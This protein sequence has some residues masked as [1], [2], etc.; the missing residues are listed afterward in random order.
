M[1]T[2]KKISKLNINN[3]EYIIKDNELNS[4]VNNISGVV[5]NINTRVSGLQL[6]MPDNSK[7]LHIGNGNI[8]TEQNI[9]I[10]EFDIYNPNIYGGYIYNDDGN[11][12]NVW[13]TLFINNDEGAGEILLDDDDNTGF[14]QIVRNTSNGTETLQAAL[15][16][17]NNVKPD[18]NA[19]SGSDAEILNKPNYASSITAGGAANMSVGIPYGTIQSGSTSTNKIATVNDITE[20]KTGIICIIQ[21]DATSSASG[22]TLNV[23]NLGAKKVYRTTAPTA[24]STTEFG[25][26]YAMGFMYDETLNS[27]AGGWRLLELYNSNTTYTNASLGQGYGTCSTAEATLA[28]TSSISN[29]TLVDGGIVAIKFNN[30]VSAGSTLNITSK[31]AKSIYYRGAAI[32][33]GVI[34]AGDVAYFIYDGTQ[35]HLLGIDR[36]GLDIENKVD[37][38][39]GKGLSTEDYTTEEKTKLANLTNELSSSYATSTGI[40]D[41]LAL[42]GGDTYEEAFGKLEKSILDSDLINATALTDLNSRISEI[43]STDVPTISQNASGTFI[44]VGNTTYSIIL[45]TP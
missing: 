7:L 5:S 12:I 42:T 29:Y 10:N 45:N 38:V 41:A 21:N 30:A 20:L 13:G 14:T 25:T 44:T 34:K 22:W 33:N 17:R 39:T 26:N 8:I 4:T 15:D 36:W 28:K 2:N 31:G 32:N 23:N 40:N 9:G 24:A 16:A 19:V 6:N 27:N 43:E 11:P 3:N 18:W 1:A 37:A 35:Y